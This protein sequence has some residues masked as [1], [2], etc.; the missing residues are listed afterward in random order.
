MYVWERAFIGKIWLGQFWY[1]NFWVPSPP[2]LRPPPPHTSP[3]CP[4][5]RAASQAIERAPPQPKPGGDGRGG[6]PPPPPA[7]PPPPPAPLPCAP[8]PPPPPGR[9]PSLQAALAARQTCWAARIFPF[10]YLGGARHA[11]DAAALRAHHITHILNVA[12]DVPNA[13]EGAYTY[14][15]LRVADF[16]RD[17]GIRRVFGEAFVFLAAVAREWEGGAGGGEH[18][19][20][21]GSGSNTIHGSSGSNT[22]HGNSG[23]RDAVREDVVREGGPR[24]DV[25]CGAGAQGGACGADRSAGAGGAGACCRGGATTQA[26]GGP[27]AAR[28][29]CLVHCAAGA[30]RSATV[31]IGFVMWYKGWD[32]QRAYRYVRECKPGICPMRDMR[33]ELVEYER[34]LTGRTTLDPTS[35][36]CPRAGAPQ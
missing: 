31:V 8:A 10:L 13:F 29:R 32:L 35:F 22:I 17:P 36:T 34:G 33:A 30:N 26:P 25:A 21:G 2:P 28:P 16:G 5:L 19:V 12:D 3:G 4:T 20:H 11:Q 18:D 1:I 27:P 15:N 9:A 24:G 7:P 23:D 6:G 14:L